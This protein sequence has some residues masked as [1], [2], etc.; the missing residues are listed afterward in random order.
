[1][2]VLTYNILGG[3]EG[4]ADP[5]AEVVLA[6]R[7]DVVALVEADVPA[8]VERI[9]R[10]LRMDFVIGR[11]PG[12]T[13]SAVLSRWPI[14]SSVNHAALAPGLTQSFLEAVVVSPVG[15]EWPV[16]VLHLP[17]GATDADEDA[18]LPELAVAL[19]L[20]RHHRDAGTP[21][22]L[23]GDLN[24]NATEG[25]RLPTRVVAAVLAA[26]YLDAYAARHDER[27][28]VVGSFTTQHPGQ[29][30]DHV[31]AFG[32]PAADVRDAWVE[33]DRLAKYASDHFPVGVEVAEECRT[34]N[35]EWRMEKGAGDRGARSSLCNLHSALRPA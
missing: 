21:H 23:C 4:R 27:R 10:R 16:A 19:D 5:L 13:A 9:A 7:A 15:P 31:F 20:L 8:V 32:I 26:G 6:Q 25:G 22:L 30:V 24:A 14:R 11:G 3:G 29:R 2:R 1:M 17:P 28:G 12:T 18:R 35:A 33:Q 34:Q